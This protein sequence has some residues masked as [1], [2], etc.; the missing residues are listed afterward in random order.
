MEAGRF[1]DLYIRYA[2]RMNTAW[3]V[4]LGDYIQSEAT[5]RAIEA[6]MGP[7]R[8]R[9]WVRSELSWYEGEPALCVMQGWF[10]HNTLNFLPNQS[11]LPVW[12]G[13]HLAPHTRGQLAELLRLDRDAFV[14]QE[15]GCRDLSTLAWCREQGLSAYFSRCL[16]LTLPRRQNAVA[17]GAGKVFVVGARDWRERVRQALPEDLRG[18]AVFMD[19]YAARTLS[20]AEAAAQDAQAKA[21]LARYAQE[22]ELV[23][24]SRLHCAQPCLAM[25]IPVV[26]IDPAMD[27]VDRFSALRGL[28]KVWSLQ[29]LDEGRVGFDP[30]C[31]DFEALKRDLIENLRLT[32]LRA[33]GREVDGAALQACRERIAAFSRLG[34]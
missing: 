9:P 28:I 8:F 16:T 4:N 34:E 24:T 25:G 1:K 21:L 18:R 27:V 19:Q 2:Y 22:A 15:I 23:V 7:V 11:I 3:D 17:K 6:A 29:D 20:P 13:T 12:V 10:E 31:P 33:L 30:V 14:D 32:L 26:F 5:A